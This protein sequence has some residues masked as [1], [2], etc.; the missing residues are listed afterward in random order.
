[1]APNDYRLYPD[2]DEIYTDQDDTSARTALF[3]NAPPAVLDQDT[4][5]A[6][7]ALLFLEQGKNED[8]M[9]LLA[10]HRYKPWEGGVVMHNMFV[11]TNIAEGK[12]ALQNH[13]S[14]AAEASF[15]K[16]LE[17]PENLGTGEPSQPDTA[18][19]MYWI[20]NALEA[21]GKSAEAKAAW[22]KAADQG[23]GK[24]NVSAVYSAL[25]YQK[26]GQDEQAQKLL[27]GCIQPAARPKPSAEDYFAA[28]TA[29]RYSNN[30]DQ[31]RKYFQQALAVDPLLW[32]ARIALKDLGS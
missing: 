29:E 30:A 19:Q 3:Q 11:F 2:L 18:E 22:Q 32:Q 13:H 5:R 4:V 8:A 31:A 28:G 27:Q 1:M 6:R 14:E 23:K 16:A 24:T 17:Y 20:G 7:R 25:A 10:N 21:Q 26:L 9:A 12:Q 15:R